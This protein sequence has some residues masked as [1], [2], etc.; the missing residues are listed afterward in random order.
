MLI[1]GTE[2]KKSSMHSKLAGTEETEGGRK[3][4]RKEGSKQARKEER[5]KG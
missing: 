1:V 5:K 4:R 3:E 2:E